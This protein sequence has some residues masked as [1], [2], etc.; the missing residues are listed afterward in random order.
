MFDRFKSKPQEPE[1]TSLGLKTEATAQPSQGKNPQTPAQPSPG[2]NPQASPPPPP[3]PCVQIS[4]GLEGNFNFYK[5]LRRRHE[6]FVRSGAR[7]ETVFYLVLPQQGHTLTVSTPDGKRTILYLFTSQIM[8]DGFL[9]RRKLGAVAAGCRV[10]SLGEQVEKWTA[11]GI[12]AYA[13]N[14]CAKCANA[15]IGPLSDLQSEQKFQDCWTL[16][17][18]NRRL[19]AETTLR[20]W[21]QKKADIPGHLKALEGIRDHVD[22][23]SPYIHM[24]IAT[25]AGMQGDKE[26]A[27]NAIQTLDRFGPPFTG[28]LNAETIVP[29]K[30]ETWSEALSEAMLGLYGAY[31]LVNIPMKP[32][33]T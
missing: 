4:L 10:S 30:V 19:F 15:A 25:M 24:M 12:N 16:D 26:T 21:Q 8:A 20:F 33:G 18:M 11:A 17:A 32:L 9:A 7:L 5:E 3:V 31:G 2:Q 23:G 6:E 14:P 27:A 28:K 22:P 1:L 13:L 29:G